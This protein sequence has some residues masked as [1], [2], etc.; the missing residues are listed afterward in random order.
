MGNPQFMHVVR[1]STPSAKVTCEC[2]K[3]EQNMTFEIR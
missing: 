1:N 2:D 3:K